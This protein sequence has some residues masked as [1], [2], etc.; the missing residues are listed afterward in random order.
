M[1]YK[2]SRNEI[3]EDFERYAYII[4]LNNV[5][6]YRLSPTEIDDYKKLKLKYKFLR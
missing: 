1:P 2:I 6:D 4:Y 5:S 3:L